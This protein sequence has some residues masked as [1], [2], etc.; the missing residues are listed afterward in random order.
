MVHPGALGIV[1]IAGAA[2]VILFII[3]AALGILVF[4]MNRD[5]DE[6]RKKLERKALVKEYKKQ[7]K[8]AKNGGLGA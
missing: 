7:Q 4:R 3:T 5:E 8:L 2:S 6:H 1:G